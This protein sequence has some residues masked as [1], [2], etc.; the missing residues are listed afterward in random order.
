MAI[1]EALELSKKFG[2]LTAVDKVSFYL[3]EGEVF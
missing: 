1:I 2:K 3:D